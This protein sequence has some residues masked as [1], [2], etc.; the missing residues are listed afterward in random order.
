MKLLLHACCGPCAVVPLRRL[1]EE[2]IEPRGV[3]ANSN[4]HPFT[5]WDRRREGLEQLA[6]A[7][8]LPLLPHEAYDPASWM[9]DVAFREGERCRVCYHRR[10]RHTAH[11][12]RR[13]RFDAYSTTLL[14]SV[15]QK[16]ELIRELGEAV[17]AEVGVP[18]FYRD[19]R[20]GWTEGIDEAKRL[21]LYRQAYCGCLL[22]EAERFGPRR[23]PKA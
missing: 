14:Y 12:A 13:G 23:G 22:S 7:E 17:A 3:F 11:L 19:W 6:G 1:R 8:G 2:G 9:R 16:H 18:F 5:E 20:A 15:R 21:G 10:L 4:V